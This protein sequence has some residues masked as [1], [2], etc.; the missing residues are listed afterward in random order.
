[1]NLFFNVTL[2]SIISSIVKLALHPVQPTLFNQSD[3]Q[4]CEDADR[5]AP[6][7]NHSNS[8]QPAANFRKLEMPDAEVW[9]MHNWMQASTANKLFL[10]FKDALQWSQP[11]ISLFG[12][13]LKVP[14]LQAWYGDKD[15]SYAYSGIQMAALAWDKKLYALKKYCEQSCQTTFNSVLVNYYRDG[16]DSMGMH[17][18]NESELGKQPIIASFSL[19]ASRN[20]DFK[21]MKSGQKH[22]VPLHHGSLLIMCGNTQQ[23]WQH[24]IHKSKRINE[25]RMNF[26]FRFVHPC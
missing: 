7:S 26:T 21:H 5:D 2:C 11:E 8:E 25:P 15:A 12:N 4:Y 3:F 13:K 19:G 20:F 9:L 10:Y 23:Y 24:G 22:R 17:A 14:R 18:D 6:G 1:M 16:Q